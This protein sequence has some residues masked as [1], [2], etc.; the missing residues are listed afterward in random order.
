MKKTTLMHYKNYH[1][2]VHFDMKE[3]IFY[4]QIEFIRDLVNYEAKDADG[5]LKSFYEAVDSYIDDCEILGKEADR[6]FKGSFNIRMD[7]SL[8]KEIALYAIE[9]GESLNGVVVEAL[10]KFMSHP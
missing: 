2:S 6:P 8:H 9:H 3:K 7:P 10:N 1:G 4:G 5:L